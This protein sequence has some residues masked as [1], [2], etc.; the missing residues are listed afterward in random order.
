MFR[1]RPKRIYLDNAAATPVD[2]RVLRR[3]LPFFERS[4]GNPLSIHREGV[5][6]RQAVEE[7]RKQVAGVLHAHPDEI[8]FTSGATEANALALLGLALWQG[9][10]SLSGLHAITTA[11]EHSSV[12]K[13]FEELK[14]RGLS[15]TVVGVNKKGIVNPDDIVRAVRPET[16]LVS[17]MFVNS[18]IGTIQPIARIA[19]TLRAIKRPEDNPL[20][21]HTDASQAPLYLSVSVEQLGVDLMTID[22]QKLYGPK[23]SGC[24]YRRRGVT[25]VPLT[26]GGNQENGLRP[27]TENVAG[28]VGLAESL[29]MCD[30]NR[31]R[32]NRRLAGLQRYFFDKLSRDVPKAHL[33]G[34]LEKRIP[35]NINISLP[36]MDGEFLTIFLDSR[37]IACGTKTACREGSTEGSAVIKALGENEAH[38][39]GTLRFSLGKQTRKRDIDT[40]VACLAEAA[41]KFDE[42]QVS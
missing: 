20:V 14:R 1:R 30:R 33:N 12:T 27:G 23:G 29:I 36:G 40:V 7:S 9:K 41:K 18:E 31:E 42:S 11:I 17:C 15:V 5:A 34:S 24:L 22:A 35:A 37:G 10:G 16:A 28:I 38:T 6:A 21:F 25:L 39:I 4:Y 3:M 2:P 13:C 32:E 8:V 19:K 26:R